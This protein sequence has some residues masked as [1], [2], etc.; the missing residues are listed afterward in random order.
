MKKYVFNRINEI[1]VVTTIDYYY[2]DEPKSLSAEEVIGINDKFEELEGGQVLQDYEDFI[3]NAINKL[4]YLGYEVLDWNI[5]NQK[6]SHYVM[7]FKNLDNDNIDTKIIFELRIS[8]HPQ[9]W[10]QFERRKGIAKRKAKKLGY[11]IGKQFDREL[12]TPTVIVNN[13]KFDN[14]KDA[15]EHLVQVVT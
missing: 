1:T 10:A 11:P 6:L 2:L 13:D 12:C 8:N 5:S 4:E 9:N 3:L 15:M 7:Y 14:Y